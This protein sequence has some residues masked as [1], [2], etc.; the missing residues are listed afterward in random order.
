MIRKQATLALALVAA[1]SFPAF[2]ETGNGDAPGGGTGIGAGSPGGPSM[3]RSGAVAPHLVTPD[4]A[5][6]GAV[7]SSNPGMIPP[8]SST[9]LASGPD[10]TVLGGPGSSVVVTHQYVNVPAGFEQRSDFQRW[11]RLR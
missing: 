11:L 7:A 9:F 2:A 1:L 10:T 6:A 3:G 4:S 8:G 5:M